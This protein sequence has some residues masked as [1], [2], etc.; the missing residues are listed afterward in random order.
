MPVQA[1]FR[2]QLLESSVLFLE[3]LH[4]P[5]FHDAQRTK[6]LLPTVQ[7]PSALARR[8]MDALQGIKRG[9][10]DTQ[11]SGDYIHLGALLVLFQGKNNLLF[12]EFGFFHPS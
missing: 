11:Y 3:L 7:S 10:R 8:D 6:L 4:F 12:R 9:R 5:Y 2:H 1:Q